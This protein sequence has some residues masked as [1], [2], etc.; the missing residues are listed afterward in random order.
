[1]TKSKPTILVLGTFSDMGA[2]EHRYVRGFKKECWDVRCMEIHQPL[3]EKVTKSIINKAVYRMFPSI[4]MHDIN[5]KILVDVRKIN[6]DVILVF[7]GM[8]LFPET[9]SELKEHTQLI[10]NY[11]PD[12][13]FEIYSR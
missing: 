5:K 10:C 2:I 8:T 3:V 7:K 6:P 9:I 4:F 13:P 12:H 11:I 1:M